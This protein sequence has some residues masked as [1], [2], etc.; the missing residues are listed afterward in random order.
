VGPETFLGP[1]MATMEASAILGRKNF[2]LVK[3]YS[4]VSKARIRLITVL[5]NDKKN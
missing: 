5:V 3:V 2:A 4:T 1:E